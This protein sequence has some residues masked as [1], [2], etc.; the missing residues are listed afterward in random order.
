MAGTKYLTLADYLDIQETV[1]EEVLAHERAT[2]QTVVLRTIELLRDRGYV[3]TDE[4]KA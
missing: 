1:Q 3:S 2:A 4:Q